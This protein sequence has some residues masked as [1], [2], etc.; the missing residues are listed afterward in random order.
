V[1]GEGASDDDSPSEAG[2]DDFPTLVQ[3]LDV[4]T[5]ALREESW[6]AERLRLYVAVAKWESAEAET[7]A[8]EASAE[9]ESSPL[10]GFG[11]LNDNTIK[12]LKS[13]LSVE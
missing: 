7:V 9:S 2:S 5:C 3:L 11:E 4:A 13:L 1:D 6:E 10:V 8:A 12:C